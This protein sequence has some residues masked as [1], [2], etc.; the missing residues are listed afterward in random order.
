MV[1]TYLVE[2]Y[3]PGIDPA[4][5]QAETDRLV[6]MGVRVAETIIASADEVCYWYVAAASVTE[7]ERA[8]ALARVRF[9]RVAPAATLPRGIGP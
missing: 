1:A 8:F 7:V 9:D 2:R 6:A 5:A 4:S 3:W